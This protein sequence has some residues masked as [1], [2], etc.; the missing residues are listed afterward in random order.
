MVFNED[1]SKI[2]S[3]GLIMHGPDAAQIGRQDF[4]ELAWHYEHARHTESACEADLRALEMDA[5][6]S[7]LM[8]T[9]G[10]SGHDNAYTADASDHAA[11]QNHG[12]EH[13]A[14]QHRG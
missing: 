3:G 2:V 1:L 7:M 8:D 14:D 5:T 9:R 4:D 13:S 10:E 12:G 6:S 11:H